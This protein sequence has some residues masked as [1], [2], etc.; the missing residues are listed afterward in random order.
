MPVGIVDTLEVIDVHEND[1][2]RCFM[3]LRLFNSILQKPLH[4]TAIQE[5][6]QSIAARQLRE[7]LICRMQFLLRDADEM[8]HEREHL[9]VVGEMRHPLGLQRDVGRIARILLH[10]DKQDIQICRNNA[11]ASTPNLTEH[12]RGR[13]WEACTGTHLRHNILTE[14]EIMSDACR[15]EN[16]LWREHRHSARVFCRLCEDAVWVA[17]GKAELR[18]LLHGQTEGEFSRPLLDLEGDTRGDRAILFLKTEWEECRIRAEIAISLNAEIALIDTQRYAAVQ[19]LDRTSIYT[20]RNN[21]AAECIP[22]EVTRHMH[23]Q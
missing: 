15:S 16:C 21:L 8:R 7:T 20:G 22:A 18:P 1:R 4:L 14:Q 10:A 19:F 17:I 6:R 12:K 11:S 2:E 23:I 9:A 3:L 13:R 5:V